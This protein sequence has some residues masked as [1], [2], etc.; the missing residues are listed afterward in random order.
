MKEAIIGAANDIGED[1]KGAGGM[2][3]YMRMVAREEVAVFGGMLRA[4]MRTQVTVERRDEPVKPEQE[5]RD[6][7]ARVGLQLRR[8]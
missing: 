8:S 2:R 4:V 3:G 7:L 6:G 5:I 1:G